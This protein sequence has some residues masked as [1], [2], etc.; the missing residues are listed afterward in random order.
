MVSDKKL[1]T[2]EAAENS[3]E[4]AAVSDSQWKAR[5]LFPSE[6]ISDREML[7]HM[8]EV[9][10]AI[11]R[12]Y[13]VPI[14]L[15]EFREVLN[16]ERKPQGVYVTVSIGRVQVG[17]GKPL[18]R[19]KPMKA[20]NGEVFSDMA[21]EVDFYYLDEFD[22]KI[23][24]ERL[25]ETFDRWGLV[26]ELLDMPAIEKAVEHVKENRSLVM[27]LDIASG[28]FPEAG[29]DA[30]L[31]YTFF[32][33]PGEAQNLGDYRSSRKVKE[34]DLL[35]QKILPRDG[36]TSGLG[37]IG[38]VF[39]PQKGLDFKLL[40]GEG[41][42]LSL[43]G[44]RLT[45]ARDGMA[46]MTRTMRKIYTA[47]GKKL[48]PAQ[49]EVSVKELTSVRG[50]KVLNLSVDNSVEITGNLPQGASVV[51]GGE[52]F[53]EGDVGTGAK[54][55][56]NQDVLINGQI[57]GQVDSGTS[58]LGRKGATN[59]RIQAR[60][61]VELKGTAE[62]CDIRAE[63]VKLLESLGSRIIASYKVQ[64]ECAKSDES[65]QR[66]TIRVGRKSYYENLL[67]SNQDE[68]TQLHETLDKIKEYFGQGII[69]RAEQ[70]HT[71]R[72]FLEQLEAIQA[73]GQNRLTHEQAQ[74]IKKLLDTIKPLNNILEEKR[75]ETEILKQKASEPESERPMVI[76]REKIT[77]PVE[78]TI[79]SVT[80]TI[81]SS[82]QGMTI[83][84]AKDGTITTTPLPTEEE[85]E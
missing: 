40:P 66:T 21:A 76:I 33:N 8:R 84:T 1:L 44:T 73:G 50:S 25:L 79:N 9:K 58:I 47:K 11:S 5:V 80:R 16:Q 6:D 2:T 17:K 75:Q 72:L 63:T 46:V 57:Y 49:I 39:P 41:S 67:K 61:T 71:Q 42:K 55:R 10:Q 28:K 65:G 38:Q 15:L 43:D 35:C 20:P 70:E 34:G 68:I 31:E 59:A 29:Q 24:L 52:I 36:K 81:E 78:V 37:V 83:T 74:S 85:G 12:E 22:Q 51:S 3:L 13:T 26:R 4:I 62:N 19:L 56:A 18:L 60:D 48:I 7:V 53:V 23:S 30:E 54:V 27:H 69:Q 82:Q 77:E 14:E 45:A 32:T 64:V